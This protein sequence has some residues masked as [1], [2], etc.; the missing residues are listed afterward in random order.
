[1]EFIFVRASLNVCAQVAK[2]SIYYCEKYSTV[3]RSSKSGYRFIPLKTKNIFLLGHAG[4]VLHWNFL[5]G[6]YR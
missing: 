5:G 2:S 3:I 1:M 4:N 6:E